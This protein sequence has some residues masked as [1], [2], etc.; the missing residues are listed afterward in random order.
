MKTTGIIR[1][2]DQLGR[3]VIPKEVRKILKIKDNDS[4]EIFLENNNIILKKYSFILNI[5]EIANKWI[6]VCNKFTDYNI[7]ITD[8]DKVV[9]CSSQEREKYLNKDISEST[10]ISINRRDNY[11]I[12]N[13]REI[14]I[15]N[16]VLDNV[17]YVFSTIVH[18]GDAMGAIILMSD[19][20]EMTEIEE[21]VALLLT[22]MINNLFID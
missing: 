1:R 6:N 16:D 21:K 8:T 18:N 9:A 7:V 10:L 4:L 11:V 3:I 17:S 19:N 15:I 13:K 2:I 12:K 20:E 5:Q 14:N 22:E